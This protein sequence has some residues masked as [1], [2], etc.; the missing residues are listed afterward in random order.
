MGQAANTHVILTFDIDAETLWTSRDKVNRIGPVMLSQGFYGP[1]VGVPRIL[2]LL[3][4][5]GLPATFF[6][7]GFVADHY[8]EVCRAIIEQG[9]EIAHHNYNHEW[10][11]RTTPEEEKEAFKLG[12]EA[13][14]RLTGK[15]PAGYRAPGWEFSD[16]TFEL[17]REY[18]IRYSSNMM[19]DEKPYEFTLAG[20]PTGI[21]ELPVSWILDDAAFFMHGLTYGAP[22]FP[23]SAV[24][25]QWKAEFDGMYAEG[26]GRVYVLTMHPQIIGRSSRMAM[27]EELIIYMQSRPG[28]QFH[29]AADMTNI[30]TSENNIRRRDY[31]H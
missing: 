4:K 21:I 30:V 6:V 28:A 19:D 8:P 1:E 26:D 27:L 16:I 31:D 24:L 15:G 17:L 29:R 25:E 5:H 22:M 12:F 2:K 20:E 11:P 7:T 9:H 14:R 3:E 18:G 23:P 10:P 13:L